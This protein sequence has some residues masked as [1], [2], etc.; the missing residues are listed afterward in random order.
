MKDDDLIAYWSDSLEAIEAI[1]A[2]KRKLEGEN[3][4]KL[5]DH[6]KENVVKQQE[7]GIKHD[8]EKPE[9]ALLSPLWVTGVAD[10]LTFGARKY[11]AHNWRKGLAVSRLISAALRHIFLFMAGQDYD[12]E[13]G[14]HHLLHASCCLM[15]AYETLMMR[16]A[17]DDRWRADE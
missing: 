2:K 7:A 17:F 3:V 8:Q 4:K 11:A 10:V 16:P 5:L 13:S 6:Y 15:F 12:E 9:M 1:E 14:K